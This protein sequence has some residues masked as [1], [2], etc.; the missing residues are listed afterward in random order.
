MTNAEQDVLRL[1]D[2]HKDTWRN[3]SQWYWLRGLL[4][5]VCELI[6]ALL[7]IHH[8]PVDWELKQIAAIAMNWLE[9]REGKP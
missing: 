3:C 5:E 9:M 1:K 4:E 7:G 8:G 6:G 2:L